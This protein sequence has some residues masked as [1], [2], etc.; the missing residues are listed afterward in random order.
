MKTWKAALLLAAGVVASGGIGAVIFKPWNA[1]PLATI[2]LDYK[3][4]MALNTIRVGTVDQLVTAD[5][6]RDTL[7]GGSLYAARKAMFDKYLC[8]PVFGDRHD[9]YD[10]VNRQNSK[11]FDVLYADNGSSVEH[12]YGKHGL[13]TAIAPAISNMR[14]TMAEKLR[15]HLRDP[16]NLR[17]AYEARKD[18]IIAHLRSLDLKERKTAVEWLQSAQQAFEAF[19]TPEMQ[20]AY[21]AMVAAERVWLNHAHQRWEERKGTVVSFTL[22]QLDEELR[23]FNKWEETNDRLRAL[24][25]NLYVVKYAGRR[26]QEG[27]MELI[28][29][30]TAIIRDVIAAVE[31]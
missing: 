5:V 4:G 26:Q 21:Q 13:P 14:T 22:D 27:G 16:H 24:A 20:D 30:Y 18:I 28:N 10:S 9:D 11:C 31:K 2:A 29:E 17:A 12:W 25:P 23:P 7:K 8:G 1:T 6:V 3:L 19:S 15:D